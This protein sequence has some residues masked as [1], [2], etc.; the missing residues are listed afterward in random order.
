[1]SPGKPWLSD[2]EVI[3]DQLNLQ[4]NISYSRHH[5]FMLKHGL[6]ACRR[7][8]DLGTGNGHFLS[9]VAGSHSSIRFYGIDDKPHMI[10]AAKERDAKN[11]EWRI[12]DVNDFG[13]LPDLRGIDGILMRYFI[14]HLPNIREVLARIAGSVRKGTVL[15]IFDVDL[16]EFVCDP[17]HRA[18]DLIKDL[19]RRFCDRFS[20]ESEAASQLPDILAGAGF[21]FVEKEIEPFSNKEMESRLFEKFLSQEVYLYSRFLRQRQNSRDM[22]AIRHFIR[23]EVASGDHEVRYGMVMVAARRN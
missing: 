22:T 7:V 9:K 13:K 10:E 15:W 23:H 18:F 1:M 19:A 20:N 11:V 5:A 16:N 6:A 8:L 21:A 4:V 3:N 2:A 17:P 12:A 14:L